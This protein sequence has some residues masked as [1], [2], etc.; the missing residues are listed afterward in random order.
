MIVLGIVLI[1]LGLVLPSLVPTFAFAHIVLILG[2]IFLA[3]GLFLA[4]MGRMG[5]AVAGRR[6]YY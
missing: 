4:V 2:V 3:V 5:H 1:V 6:H